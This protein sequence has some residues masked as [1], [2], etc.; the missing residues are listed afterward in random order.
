MKMTLFWD[1]GISLV[2][3]AVNTSETSVNLYQTIR[4]NI[5]EDSRLHVTF[6]CGESV[7]WRMLQNVRNTKKYL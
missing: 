6:G 1:V 7:G 3:G 2:V 4:Y 5:P